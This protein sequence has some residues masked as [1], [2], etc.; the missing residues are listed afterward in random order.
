MSG[1]LL[2]GCLHGDD[3]WPEAGTVAVLGYCVVPSLIWLD[4]KAVLH[5][6][7]HMM[8]LAWP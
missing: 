5:D 2:H 4:A 3:F 6:D 8:E 7:C 1:S